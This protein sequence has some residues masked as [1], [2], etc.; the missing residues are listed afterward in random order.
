[1]NTAA[2]FPAALL[3]LCLSG[4]IAGLTLPA[5]ALAA[6]VD[7]QNLINIEN[8]ASADPV[9]IEQQ[10][11]KALKLARAGQRSQALALL[12]PLILDPMRFPSIMADYITILTWDGQT[13]YAID[14]YEHLPTTFN[15]P[16]YLIRDVAQAYINEKQFDS[17]VIS[18]QNLLNRNPDDEQSQVSLVKGLFLSGRTSEAEEKL[19]QFMRQH[20]SSLEL[21]LIR[22]WMLEQQGQLWRAVLEYETISKK[23]PGQTTST[24]RAL[25]TMSRTGASSYALELAMQQLPFDLGLHEQI[26]GDIAVD[27]LH[28]GE[29]EAALKQLQPMRDKGILRARYDTIVALVDNGRPADAIQAYNDMTHQDLAPPAWVKKSVA[30]A[31]LD[32]RQP[33]EALTLYKEA[34]ADDPF[35]YGARMG[36]ALA[37]MDLG[38]LRQARRILDELD[39]ENTW[40]IVQGATIRPNQ[41]KTEIAIAQGWLL[42]D[43]D[44]LNKAEKHFQNLLNLAP[45]HEEFRGG[46]AQTYLYR[47]WPRKALMGFQIM[48]TLN[49]DNISAIMGRISVQ[50]TLAIKKLARTQASALQARHPDNPQVRRL[51]RELEVDAMRMLRLELEIE[52]DNDGSSDLL[53][54]LSYAHPLT[55]STYLT[56]FV[57]RRK[58]SQQIDSA[59]FERV[60]LGVEHTFNSVWQLGETLSW[61]IGNGGELGTGTTLRV[62]PDDYW[63]IEL[64]YDS[65]S[66]D[67]ALRARAAGI[68][69]SRFELGVT[70]RESDWREYA[71]GLNYSRFSDGNK[72]NEGLVRYEQGLWARENWVM[73][74][75]LDVYASTNSLDNAVYFNPSSD[76]SISATHV[77]THTFYRRYEKR[78]SHSLHLTAGNYWQSGF[79]G[80]TMGM[81][82]YAQNY[83]FTD[84]QALE[85]SIA[86]ASRPYDGINVASRSYY[87]AYAGKF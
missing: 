36:K 46:L 43:E 57:L 72:R 58:S 66:T 79:S 22:P 28:W 69:A 5:L 14:I 8:I 30:R 1:M 32:V 61:D 82:R 50:N 38:Q 42:A 44:A 23:W 25:L 4:V 20:P 3:L 37:L 83:D 49:N 67:V 15:K 52:D 35:S 74:L 56:G 64:A 16:D 33:E 63:R 68:D 13:A 10:Y 65:F 17:A 85:W 87:L 12:T 2:P 41:N 53:V 47:G 62:T 70:Y 81:I 26:M 71:I 6:D 75:M 51:M 34:L 19:E 59:I 45:A 21:R 86:F 78:F 29:P 73:R 24:K 39:E 7:T 80:K 55:L 31:W 9:L 60:G 54:R 76:W 11:Q 18:F 48:A 84:T 40:T 27:H 77:T